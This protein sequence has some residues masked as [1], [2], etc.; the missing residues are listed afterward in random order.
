MAL[1]TETIFFFTLCNT[2]FSIIAFVAFCLATLKRPELKKWIY[3][4]FLLMLGLI[5][6]IIGLNDTTVNLIGQL[7][8]LLASI[9][10]FF[11]A[12]K[13]YRNFRKARTLTS[14]ALLSA[15][16]V[17]APING[18]SNMYI[19]V[20]LTA[21]VLTSSLLEAKVYT[22]KK[23]PTHLFMTFALF[24]QTAVTIVTSLQNVV[25]EY[26]FNLVA[27]LGWMLTCFSIGLM[28]S[29]A[30]AANVEVMMD[31]DRHALK[32]ANDAANKQLEINQKIAEELS[33]ASIRLAS[34]SEE[35]TSSS[36]NI[37]QTQ[38]QITKGAQSQATMVVETQKRIK[39]LSDGIGNIKKNAEDITQVVDLI[40][41][42]ANQTNLLA[43]N[44]AIEAARAGDAGRGFSV[45]ADQVRKL[46]DESKFA[47]KRTDSMV[48]QILNVVQ[49]QAK[50]AVD[51]VQSIDSIASVAEETSAS[52]EE[53]SAAAEEQSSSMEEITLTAQSMAELAENLKK[54][55]SNFN[56]GLKN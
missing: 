20:I 6:E 55:V 9:A 1:S 3:A 54:Q 27:F 47:V 16:A 39:Q 56:L 29:T 49:S 19:Y 11:A 10:M 40:T 43:L 25:E 48:T 2:I 46:A 30:I 32:I 8:F 22:W 33:T 41:S 23:T 37:A 53:A 45:V 36:A 14:A 24:S 26:Y 7:S 34:S 5:L 28:L 50:S 15:F 35:V 52:T 17:S 13:E 38:Q 31:K 21:I 12:L 4:Y 44:A 51:V 18:N 42:L